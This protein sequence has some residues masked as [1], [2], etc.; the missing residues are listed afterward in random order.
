MKD[1]ILLRHAKAVS[2]H[3]GGDIARPLSSRG[4]QQIQQVA[5]TFRARQYEP[6][7]ALVSPAIRTQQT[8]TLL[9]KQIGKLDVVTDRTLYLATDDQILD[10]LRGVPDDI[11]SLLLVGHNPGISEL[12]AIWN[13]AYRKQSLPTAG[14]IA[15]QLSINH[16][17]DI[18]Q[19]C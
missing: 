6:E 2:D 10:V 13:P 4:I 12:A 18:R 19:S 11:Q 14:F 9:G 5:H 7:L 3:A 15:C 16:W 17:H 1:L 8:A